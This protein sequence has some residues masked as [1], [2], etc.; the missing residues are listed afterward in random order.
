MG[1]KNRVENVI[2]QKVTRRRKRKEKKV[3]KE[4]KMSSLVQF[5]SFKTSTRDEY[6]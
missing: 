4:E 2:R 6:S 3:S 5:S 1:E